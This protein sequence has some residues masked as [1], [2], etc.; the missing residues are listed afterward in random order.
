MSQTACF[1]FAEV[2]QRKSSW[3]V[4][5][6]SAVWQTHVWKTLQGSATV[7]ADHSCCGLWEIESQRFSCEASTHWTQRK[8]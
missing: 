4:K 1:V 6:P 2:V 3:Q 5:Q 8:R 7:Q